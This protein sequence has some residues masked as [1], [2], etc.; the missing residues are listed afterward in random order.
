[1]WKQR[2]NVKDTAIYSEEGEREAEDTADNT[3]RN[4]GD[5]SKQVVGDWIRVLGHCVGRGLSNMW[6]SFRPLYAS[7]G[8]NTKPGTLG[9]KCWSQHSSGRRL[10]S[11]T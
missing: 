5:G 4:E 11:G 7:H 9:M 2:A 10:Q 8:N 3:C 6:C 1:M